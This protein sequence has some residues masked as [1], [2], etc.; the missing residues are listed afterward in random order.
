MAIGRTNTGGGGTGATLVVTGVAGDTCVISKDG[1]SKTQ[2]FNSDGTVTFKGLASGSW[3]VTMSDGVQATSRNLLITAD[4]DLTMAYR[5]IP[6][7]TYTGDC[8]IVTDNDTVIANPSNYVGNW[9]IRFLTSGTLK[10]TDLHGCSS[11]DIFL[12][13]GGGGSAASPYGRNVGGAGGYT[14]TAFSI[15]LSKGIEYAINVG[16][17]GVAANNGGSTTAFGKTANGG[18]AGARGGQP[19]G[20]SGGGRGTNVNGGKAGNGGTDGG[21]GGS[22]DEGNGGNG[23]ATTTREFGETAGKLYAGGGGGASTQNGIGGVGGDGGGGTGTSGSKLGTNGA[24]NTGGGA[25]G[26]YNNTPLNG[27][28][29]IVVIRN[30]R[31]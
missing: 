26:G 3:T 13:G 5:S 4:Y 10:F 2:T 14:T 30:A 15:S 17:G 6:D 21:N 18:T 9:K 25:G 12:V 19:N 7:F 24:T 23:Q 8:E 22:S 11:I 1:K 16:A 29:G 20:G 27:G 28:S 31:E